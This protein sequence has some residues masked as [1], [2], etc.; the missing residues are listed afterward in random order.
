M[1]ALFDYEAVALAKLERSNISKVDQ[2][3]D[4]ADVTLTDG[5][6][7]LQRTKESRRCSRREI[8]RKRIE[9]WYLKN[10]GREFSDDL[11]D[12]EEEDRALDATKDSELHGDSTRCAEDKESKLVAESQ[13]AAHDKM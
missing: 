5:L 8:R 3:L 2:W 4:G 13:A 9:E 7:M 10:R 11:F 12:E 6:A 1:F